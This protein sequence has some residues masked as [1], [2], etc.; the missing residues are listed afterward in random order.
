[1]NPGIEAVVHCAAN[2]LVDESRRYPERYL[3]DN[4][5]NGTNLIVAA[6]RFN[7]GRFLLVSTAGIFGADVPVPI[8][9]SAPVFPGSPYGESLYLLERVLGWYDR[10]AGLRF[11][12]LRCFNV[13]GATECYGEYRV[14]QIHL[15]PALLDVALD[16]RSHLTLFGDTYPTPDGSCMR[17][18]IHVLNV[19]QAIMRVVQALDNHSRIYNLGSGTGHS[20][21]EV[22]ALARRVTGQPIPMWSSPV[23]HSSQRSRSPRR[24]RFG[25]SWAGS[26]SSPIWNVLSVVPGPGRASIPRATSATNHGIAIT[27]LFFSLRFYFSDC[28]VPACCRRMVRLCRRSGTLQRSLTLV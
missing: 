24:R 7:V 15:I 10:V 2:A 25:E 5:T 9:E 23:G 20:T 11:A 22:I 19:A 17:D 13:A 4:V 28:L 21:K 8:V 14:P 3:A 27:S 18:Y 1:M 26:R 6:V 12:S 16:Q